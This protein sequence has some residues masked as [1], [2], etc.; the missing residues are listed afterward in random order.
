MDKVNEVALVD[1]AFRKSERVIVAETIRIP[2][3]SEADGP[4]RSDVKGLCLVTSMGRKM[5]AVTSGLHELEKGATFLTKIGNF[6]DQAVIGAFNLNLASFS[7]IVSKL[8]LK[9]PL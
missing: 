7:R 1:V 3:K 4:V 8:K 5:A 9:P 2:P 6:S